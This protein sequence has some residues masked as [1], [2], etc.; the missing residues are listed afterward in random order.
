MLR[1]DIRWR[2]SYVA[3]I[4]DGTVKIDEKSKEEININYTFAAGHPKCSM[5]YMDGHL[6]V[7][8][9][10]LERCRIR[11]KSK[12]YTEPTG[13]YKSEIVV[14]NIDYSINKIGINVVVIDKETGKVDDSI[15]VNTYS[16]GTLK[17]N[18]S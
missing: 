10:P 9:M 1:K 5:E 2:E 4:D 17:I 6:K 16:D 8:C 15:N 13:A 7:D 3:I 11:V 12:G 18:R 14:D